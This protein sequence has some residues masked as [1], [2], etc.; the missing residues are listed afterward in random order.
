[1][2]K[3]TLELMEI[4]SAFRELSDQVVQL[5]SRIAKISENYGAPEQFSMELVKPVR[6][7]EAQ[8]ANSSA[9][10]LP[11]IIQFPRTY[12]SSSY[13]NDYSASGI[14]QMSPLPFVATPGNPLRAAVP[15][16]RPVLQRDGLILLAWDKRR[17]TNGFSFT[18]YWVTSAGIPRFYASKPLSLEDFPSARPFRKSYAAEDGIEYYGQEAPV[19]IVHVAPE[20]MKSNPRHGELRAVHI[21]ILKQH[22]S[23]VDFKY[24]YLLKNEKNRSFGHQRKRIRSSQQLDA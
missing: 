13:G 17:S 23:K 4:T 12:Q 24:E 5:G 1:M 3:N 6:N 2:E 19:Y 14:K 15:D 7:I 20:L 11:N 16:F 8:R 9:G 18:A 10:N 21:S 22:G